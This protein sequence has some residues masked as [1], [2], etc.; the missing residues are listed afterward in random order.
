MFSPVHF[1]VLLSPF[2][3]SPPAVSVFVFIAT[4]IT[5]SRESLYMCIFCHRGWEKYYIAPKRNLNDLDKS[6]QK[7][8]F[9]PSFLKNLI[10]ILGISNLFVICVY[11]ITTTKKVKSGGRAPFGSQLNSSFGVPKYF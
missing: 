6:F 5:F 11:I 9:S 1:S 2:T 8:L 10:P 4:E 7:L 3:A